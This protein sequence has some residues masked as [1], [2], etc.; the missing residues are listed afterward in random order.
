MT[1]GRLHSSDTIA[2]LLDAAVSHSAELVR[3]NFLHELEGPLIRPA[4]TFSPRGEGSRRT[5][6]RFSAEVSA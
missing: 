6:R 3:G 4:G 1:Y 5:L 2:E